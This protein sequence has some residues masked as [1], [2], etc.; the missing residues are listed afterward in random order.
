MGTCQIIWIKKF[1]IKMR[2]NTTN[3]IFCVARKQRNIDNIY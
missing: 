1:S 3:A 2:S